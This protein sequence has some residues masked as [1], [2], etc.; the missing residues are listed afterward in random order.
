MTYQFRLPQP[1]L[2]PRTSLQR[3]FVLGQHSW[4]PQPC[5]AAKRLRPLL[6][7]NYDSYT[8]N[9]YQIIAEVYGGELL[10][11]HAS[12]SRHT[13]R[14]P[15]AVERGPCLSVRCCR[16]EFGSLYIQLQPAVAPLV[17]Y[18][19]G[20]DIAHIQQLLEHDEA[21]HVILSPGPGSPDT[22]ADIGTLHAV[23]GSLNVAGNSRCQQYACAKAASFLP[24]PNGHEVC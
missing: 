4:Q 15:P 8:Y 2:R 6:I 24:R 16:L 14:T 10:C 23:F 17:Y 13:A 7:D 21:H 5:H 20:A 22:P 1:G 18:N 19:D 11:L 9:L 3:Q 12:L